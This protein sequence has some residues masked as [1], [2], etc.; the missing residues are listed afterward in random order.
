MAKAMKKVMKSAVTSRLDSKKVMKK[1]STK[2][3]SLK[4]PTM[5]RKKVDVAAIIPPLLMRRKTIHTEAHKEVG[6][7]Q[8]YDTRLLPVNKKFG[9]VLK[10]YA[11]E[12]QALVAPKKRTTKKRRM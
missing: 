5:K 6:A 8:C 4:L 9:H 12:P 3:K 2:K 7:F 1:K 11:K 10:A